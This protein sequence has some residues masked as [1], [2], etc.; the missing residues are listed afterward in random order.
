MSKPDVGVYMYTLYVCK[1][2]KLGKN[3]ESFLL[4]K[5]SESLRQMQV[6]TL[7]PEP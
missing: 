2:T 1:S 6:L 7:N 5:D 4:G 3:S